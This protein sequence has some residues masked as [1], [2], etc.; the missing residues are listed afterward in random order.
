MPAN[1]KGETPL[2]SPHS[3][4]VLLKN[5]GARIR[6]APAG[7]AKSRAPAETEKIRG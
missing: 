6:S 3:L 7:P 2:V 4:P 1:R 5:L